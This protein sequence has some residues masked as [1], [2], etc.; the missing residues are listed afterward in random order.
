MIS[1][2]CPLQIT[3]RTFLL[4][5]C[6]QF[7]QLL[8]Q[9]SF[10]IK[11]NLRNLP[12]G[13]LKKSKTKM[14]LLKK[15]LF[16]KNLQLILKNKIL[17]RLLE[18][19]IKNKII[20]MKIR[21]LV[22]TKVIARRNSMVQDSHKGRMSSQSKKIPEVLISERGRLLTTGML[23]RNGPNRLIQVQRKSYLKNIKK[24]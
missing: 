4:Q 7:C 16:W 11:R 3:T 9:I 10:L 17:N 1:N 12:K 2:S 13:S 15:A 18:S 6:A 20:K 8:I 14:V 23:L 19:K 24:A 5:I 22:I 21:N